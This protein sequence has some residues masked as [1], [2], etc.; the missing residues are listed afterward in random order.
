MA[1]AGNALLG[2]GAVAVWFDLLWAAG[3]ARSWILLGAPAA[4]V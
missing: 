1:G 3:V 2:V 4:L